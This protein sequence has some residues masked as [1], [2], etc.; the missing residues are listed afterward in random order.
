MNLIEN[1]TRSAAWDG[2]IQAEL[3]GKMRKTV[4][5]IDNEPKAT[6]TFKL[7][8]ATNAT[9]VL[10]IKLY[11]K[12]MLEDIFS[13]TCIKWWAETISQQNIQDWIHLSLC[14]ESVTELLLKW[15]NL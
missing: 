4:S 2:T 7:W 15:V 9:N 13:Q 14:D 12:K 1:P 3:I 11:S 8:D 10:I 5:K 6:R